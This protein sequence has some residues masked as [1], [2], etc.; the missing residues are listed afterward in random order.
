MNR[1]GFRVVGITSNDD[2]YTSVDGYPFIPK[3]K[4]QEIEFDYILV[5]I[6]NYFSVVREAENIWGSQI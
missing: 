1:G 2:I 4:L 3:G 6:D 5:T